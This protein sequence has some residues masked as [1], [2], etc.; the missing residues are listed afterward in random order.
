VKF[1]KEGSITVNISFDTKKCRNGSSDS[2]SVNDL[3]AGLQEIGT[4]IID[5]IDTG[6]GM[7][8]TSSL[9]QEFIQFD[10]HKSQE[11]KGSGIIIIIITII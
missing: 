1:T 4:I 9:F 5:I 2:V 6:I 11:G 7:N 8:N 10:A 3:D